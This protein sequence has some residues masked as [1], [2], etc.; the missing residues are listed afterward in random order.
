MREHQTPSLRVSKL[1]HA[2]GPRAVL[3]G[4]DLYLPQ[5]RTLALVG[6]SGCGKSTL[7]HL[8]AGLLTVR[9]G[10]IDNG[11]ARSAMLFQQPHL[12]P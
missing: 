9:E 5:G 11:F 7:L 10:R 3:E 2:F 8:C 1:G 6:P 4:I 12:L